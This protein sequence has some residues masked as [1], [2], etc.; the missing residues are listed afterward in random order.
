M[1]DFLACLEHQRWCSSLLHRNF[2]PQDFSYHHTPGW[3]D[4]NF[5]PHKHII[6]LTLQRFDE[7]ECA[8]ILKCLAYLE[9]T[10]SGFRFTQTQQKQIS[11]SQSSL[12]ESQKSVFGTNAVCV[13]GLN[14]LQYICLSLIYWL[15]TKFAF[16]Y[17]FVSLSVTYF[18]TS[19][20][21]V[22]VFGVMYDV[23]FLNKL[24]L[25][26]C[27]RALEFHDEKKEPKRM[28]RPCRV[29][30]EISHWP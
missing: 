9:E 18:Q 2:R 13:R 10:Q 12:I 5:W 19:L 17:L 24:W 26:L 6:V 28:N 7:T 15:L 22:Q 8:C 23:F 3:A 11:I 21:N 4:R 29:R 30:S 20:I 1:R 14:I 27:E 16:Q 25:L